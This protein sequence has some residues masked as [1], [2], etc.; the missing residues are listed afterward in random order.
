MSI[1]TPPTTHRVTLPD[2]ETRT[3][4]TGTPVAAILPKTSREGFP[5]IAVRYDNKIASLGR[6]I[7][8]DARID[9]V[10]QSSRDGGL[11]YRRSLTFLLIRA[12]HDLFPDL[13]VYINHSLNKGYYG[14]VYNELLS[15]EGPAALAESDIERIKARMREL[16]AADLPFIRREMP[17]E[18]ARAA[19]E[20]QGL[21]DKVELL[22]YREDEVVSVYSLGDMV[23]HFYGQLAPSTGVLSTFDLKSCGP[24]FV[25]LF[26]P[27]GEPQRLPDYR[28]EP[29][30][31][32]VFQEYE[33]WARIL[34]VRTV[35]QLNGL[36]DT[37]QIN[38]YV[39]IAEA[40]MEKKLAALA[41]AITN[42]PRKPRL[43][44]LSGPS[45][46]GKTTTVKRLS[47]QLRVNGRRA[48]VIGLDDFFVEREKTPKD[49]KG[50]YDF[51]A[52]GAID[53]AALQRTVRGLLEG[54]EVAL[55]KFDFI[56][57]KPVEGHRVRLE[58][59][60]ILILEGIHGLNPNLLPAFPDGMKYKIYISPL[61]HLNV[62]DHNRIAS[63]DARLI[64][65]LV[66]DSRYRG[67]TA[68]QTLGRWP[69]VRRGEERNIFP[70]QSE[71]DSII[72]SALPYEICVLRQFAVPLLQEVPRDNPLFSE[73]A[74]LLKFM[75]YFRNIRQEIVPR[76][77]ILREFIGGS[78]FKY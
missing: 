52:F 43:V 69:S 46:S 26:P 32:D 38:E 12:I 51:E 60:Q 53:V 61:T 55:P 54:R 33:R 37:R 62:D 23:N 1:Q 17:L 25:L 15:A 31:F 11:I 19:F 63:S 3:V 24:G 71:A 77:S 48:L 70:Y 47:I 22:R 74:R 45:S 64:R 41:D 50:E 16:V 65:R 44:L 75:S 14:E 67:Y 9:T 42:H 58:K 8:R 2:G 6:P 59:D 21:L 35:A 34:G 20:K 76:H 66:R 73:A 10:D 78:S 39:L 4:P 40:L 27:H 68:I 13:K 49:E 18:E 5:V 29:R 28:H 72:N 7:D 30:I 56:Q 36:V 57:G